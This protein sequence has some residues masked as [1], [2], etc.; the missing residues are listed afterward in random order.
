MFTREDTSTL[1][2]PDNKI[3][4]TEPNLQLTKARQGQITCTRPDPSL[5]RPRLSAQ[6]LHEASAFIAETLTSVMHKANKEGSTRGHL[7]QSYSNSSHGTDQ[8]KQRKLLGSPLMQRQHSKYRCGL[9]TFP[10]EE[11]GSKFPGGHRQEVPLWGNS[12]PHGDWH[13]GQGQQAAQVEGCHLRV[14]SVC[15]GVHLSFY[16]LTP[17]VPEERNRLATA[18]QDDEDC[19]QHKVE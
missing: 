5:H 10:H 8:G 14:V 19:W 15:P 4:Q 13:H 16:H 2:S 1:P 9:Y 7:N 3:L 18:S 12:P 6:G 11:G 17:G